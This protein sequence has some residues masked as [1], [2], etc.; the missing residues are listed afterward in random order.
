MTS[1]KVM[2][3]FSGTGGFSKGFE[4][5][6]AFRVNYGIDVLPTAIRTFE[7]NHPGAVAIA[8]DIREVR[9]TSVSK[10]TAL[11]RGGVDVIVGGPPCQGFSSI[12]PFR[13]SNEDDPRNSLFEEFASYINF[14]R[15]PV[16]VMENVVGLATHNKGFAIE[17][18]Q[19]CFDSLGYITDWRIMNTAHFGVPQKRERLVM[20]GAQNGI[21]VK[22][23]SPTHAG[24]FKTIGI[25]DRSRRILPPARGEEPTLFANEEPKLPEAITVMEAI[26]DLPPVRAGAWVKTYDLEPQNDYQAARRRKAE[27]LEWHVATAHTERMLQI[28][29]HAGSN[30]NSVPKHLISSGF[31]SCYSR[32]DPDQPAVTLTVNFVHPASNKCIHPLQDRALTLREGARLQSFDD[33]FHFSGTRTQIAKQIGNAVPPLLGQAIA[34]TVLDMLQGRTNTHARL[35]PSAEG[36][37][38]L[39]S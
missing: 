1:L 33:D 24:D 28:I 30:I 20:I 36:L 34:E 31:S 23:P 15:P 17:Q 35:G 6:G 7:Q 29:R 16:F 25:R 8:A 27:R 9:L 21:P 4:N 22:F 10:Q 39:A 38:V 19:E 32:L 26:G 11:S 2:D 14:F 37:T 5:T 3:L 12:R 18:I 13:S